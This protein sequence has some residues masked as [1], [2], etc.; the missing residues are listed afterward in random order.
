MT[1][2]IKELRGRYRVAHTALHVVWSRAVGTRD[3]NKADW[4]VLEEEID[5]V[6]RDSLNRLGFKGPLLP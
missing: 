5:R 1:D 6:F 3:Y 4:K 2:E